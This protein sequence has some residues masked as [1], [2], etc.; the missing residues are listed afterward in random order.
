MSRKIPTDGLSYWAVSSLK[1]LACP[2][3]PVGVMQDYYDRQVFKGAVD[4]TQLSFVGT[5]GFTFCGLMGP[6]GQIITSYVGPR[7]VMLVGTILMT[8]G[9]ILASFSKAVWHL[10]ITQS[11]IHGMGA[12][13]MYIVSMS[14]S[15]QW[16]RKRRGFAMGVMVSGSG[17]G[18]LI[19][20]FIMNA[21]NESLGG[22][23]C[24]RILGIITFV[25]SSLA[26]VLLREKP[27]TQ[28]CPK[29]TVQMRNIVDFSVCKDFKFI[30]WCIAGNLSMMAY[31]IPAFYLPSHATKLGL[32]P[33]QGSVLV[34]MFSAVNVIGRVLSGYLGDHLGAVNVDIIFL[35]LCGMSSLFIWTFAASYEALMMFILTYGLL[36]G[37]VFSLLAPITA[38]I[39]GLERY[40]SG[41]S[42]YLFFLTAARLGPSLA[43][44]I[45]TATN[46]HSYFAQ[47]IFTGLAFVLSA[48]VTVYLK[49]NLKRRPLAKV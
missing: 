49:F 34:A 23:W 24:Y 20:P 39:T 42:L 43:G 32:S 7:W 2:P 21:L 18:G 36:S 27:K 3:C 48:I 19:L 45:Q 5:I 46:K 11:V 14:I 6:I 29:S 9:L 8:A 26:T 41:I 44:A 1:Q 17:V 15:P 4:S 37:A 28:I 10:Y 33:S 38:T 12:A 40:P 35:A 16:F 22:A 13:L 25:I 47:Q 30:I 31:F